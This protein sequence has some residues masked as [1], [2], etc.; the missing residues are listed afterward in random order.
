[1]SKYVNKNL[2]NKA[3]YNINL[4]IKNNKNEQTVRNIKQY[5]ISYDKISYSE[6][7]YINKQIDK[8]YLSYSINEGLDLLRKN[9]ICINK[10][11]QTYLDNYNNNIKLYYLFK[12][13][14]NNIIKDINKDKINRCKFN[15]L[16]FYYN[17]YLN[18]MK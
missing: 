8:I 14:E 2:I 5:L 16:P 1:M 13:I 7:Y 10:F 11:K 3:L 18:K 15:L 6:F 4:L 9:N 17:I 12:D